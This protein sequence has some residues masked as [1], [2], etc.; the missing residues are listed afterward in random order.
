MASTPA[1]EPRIT[2]LLLGSSI[3]SFLENVMFSGCSGRLDAMTSPSSEGRSSQT[4]E[5]NRTMRRGREA[6]ERNIVVETSLSTVSG[7][8]IQFSGIVAV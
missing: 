2:S 6:R 3:E 8:L 7:S 4:I 5:S 1:T